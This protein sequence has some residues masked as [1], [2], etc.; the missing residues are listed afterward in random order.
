MNRDHFVPS[1]IHKS[2][3]AYEGPKEQYE[4]IKA[5][6]KADLMA[7]EACMGK[8]NLNF[9]TYNVLSPLEKDCLRQCNVKMNDSK[10]LL[11]YELK[12]FSRGLPF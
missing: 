8:C 4:I 12:Y 7:S 10:L 3:N 5:S 2:L 9:D 11:D 1:G 6:F